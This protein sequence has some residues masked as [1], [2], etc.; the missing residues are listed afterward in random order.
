MSPVLVK[1]RFTN[2]VVRDGWEYIERKN[3]TPVVSIIARFEGKVVLVRQFR[4][5]LN[6]FVVEFPAGIVDPGETVE[7]AALRELKEETGYTGKIRSVLPV[8]AKSPGI[9]DEVTYTVIVDC[10]SKG[11]QDLRDGEKIEVL[12]VL[13]YRSPRTPDRDCTILNKDDMLST[14][15]SMFLFNIEYF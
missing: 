11:V 2:Y 8:S 5:P 14:A 12:E 15:V 7:Q 13:P 3:N 1:G 9:T 4:K 10:I 6:K